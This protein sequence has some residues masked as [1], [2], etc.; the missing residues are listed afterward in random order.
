MH[1]S[2]NK[3]KKTFKINKIYYLTVAYIKNLKTNNWFKKILIVFVKIIV[4]TKNIKP[5]T[6]NKIHTFSLASVK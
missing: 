1:L 4:K 5:R 6:T 2:P 3:S